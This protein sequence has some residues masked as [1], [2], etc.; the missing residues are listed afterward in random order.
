MYPTAEVK[1]KR[2]KKEAINSKAVMITDTETLDQLKQD[3]ADKEAKVLE[4]E[5]KLR[6]KEQKRK[7]KELEQ[8]KKKTARSNHQIPIKT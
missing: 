4:K 5:A 7:A 6:E 2:K 3:K 8:E 1:S